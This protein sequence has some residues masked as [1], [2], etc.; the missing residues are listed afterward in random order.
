MKINYYRPK[1]DGYILEGNE[2][3]RGYVQ[4][5]SYLTINN[6]TLLAEENE[7]LKE[8][9]E[10]VDTYIADKVKAEAKKMVEEVMR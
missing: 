6:T 9:L 2:A 4:M 8:K 10:N 1:D 3:V 5:I 7:K